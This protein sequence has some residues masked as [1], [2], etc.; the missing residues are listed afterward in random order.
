MSEENIEKVRRLLCDRDPSVMAA[1]LTIF[2]DLVKEEKF[3]SQLKDLV[4]QFIVI[5]KQIVDHRLSRDYDYHR[6]PAPW[7][8]IK[9]LQ[10]LAQLGSDDQKTSEGMYEV[11]GEALKR[12]DDTGINAGYAI[13]FQCVVT[14]TTI[15][16]YTS[17]LEKAANSISRFI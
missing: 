2:L 10:I 9:L 17:L 1:S 13:V 3:R 6:L 8:Q 16:P 5:L 11:I 12:A 7:I 4:P 14:I 15:Y